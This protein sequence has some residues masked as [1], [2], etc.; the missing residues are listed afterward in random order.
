MRIIK[1]EPINFRQIAK[2]T[3]VKKGKIFQ[4]TWCGWVVSGHP[5]IDLICINPPRQIGD[6]LNGRT[7]DNVRIEKNE[8]VYET[9]EQ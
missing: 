9:I 8:W 2:E 1:T 4:S 7:I 5:E 3:G 6:P